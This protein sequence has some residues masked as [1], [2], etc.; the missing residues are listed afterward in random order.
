MN[1]ATF[2]VAMPVTVTIDPE[3]RL[4]ITRGEGMVTD[5]EF[6]EAREQL[7]AN[8]AFDPAFD[9]IWDFYSITEAR[10]SEDV[11]ARLIDTSPNSEKPICRAVVVSERTGPMTAILHFINRVRQ[12]NRRIAAFPDRDHAEKWDRRLPSQSPTR[13]AHHSPALASWRPMSTI[14]RRTRRS[15]RSFSLTRQGQ[16]KPDWTF[17]MLLRHGVRSRLEYAKNLDLKR[18][19]S[20]SNPDL[21]RT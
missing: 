2:L 1:V 8:P 19:R 10:V 12:T 20:L 9:R 21:A 18:A 11:A 6:L 13:L 4:T 14:L 17:N 16:E 3:R 15:G 5:E 7:L